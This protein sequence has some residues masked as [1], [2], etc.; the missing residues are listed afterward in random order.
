MGN[1]G[2]AREDGEKASY[3]FRGEAAPYSLGRRD[4]YS[5]GLML[6]IPD[7]AMKAS[8]VGTILFR[9]WWKVELV[10]VVEERSTRKKREFSGRKRGDRKVRKLSNPIGELSSGVKEEIEN[11]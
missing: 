10:T 4:I 1:G 9:V 11:T 5:K 6:T 2:L 8:K 3:V 7:E